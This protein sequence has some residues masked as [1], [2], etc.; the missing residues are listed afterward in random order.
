MHYGNKLEE[1]LLHIEEQKLSW[2]TQSAVRCYLYSVMLSKEIVYSVTITV[3]M[4]KWMKFWGYFL[5]EAWWFFYLEFSGYCL[6]LYCNTHKVLADMS[7]SL[8]PKHCEY[9]KED[10]DNSPILLRDRN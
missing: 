6:H 8:T 2:V 3:T 9:N 5:D 1:T 7:F 10:E 4:I